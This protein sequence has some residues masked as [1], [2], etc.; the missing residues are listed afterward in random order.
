MAG[1][2]D[3]K[4]IAMLA[5]DGVEQV[6]LTAPRDAVTAEGARVEIISI[7]DGKIQAM[8]GDIEPRTRSRSTERS[9]RHRRA[10]T[11]RC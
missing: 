2:L 9:P 7:K 3:G 8:N 4:R 1:K 11:T 6:E 5:T 10:T